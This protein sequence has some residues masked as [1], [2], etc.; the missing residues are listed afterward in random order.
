[1][2][3]PVICKINQLE[4]CSVCLQERGPTQTT[5]QWVRL[6]CGHTLHTR[7]KNQ[8]PA[9]RRCPICRRAFSNRHVLICE[10]YASRGANS[11]FQAS[12]SNDQAQVQV[13]RQYD[14]VMGRAASASASASRKASTHESH[15]SRFGPMPPP[16][17]GA[18]RYTGAWGDRFVTGTGGKAKRKT[19]VSPK[20]K[21][22]VTTSRK[23]VTT[24][25][26]TVKRGRTR[27]L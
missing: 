10:A 7:C 1:M 9:P 19:P 15:E 24:P 27:K 3:T 5:E 25:R 14:R 8:I 16:P 13:N 23:T 17:P 22:K 21:K 18:S 11:S 2:A 12:L 6:P 26:K 20:R 4:E